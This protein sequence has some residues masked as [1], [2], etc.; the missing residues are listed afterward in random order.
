MGALIIQRSRFF[1]FFFK[2]TDSIH[3]IYYLHC[4][5]REDGSNLTADSFQFENYIFISLKNFVSG[6]YYSL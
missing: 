5:P 6:K 2:H 1:F 3:I 4:H